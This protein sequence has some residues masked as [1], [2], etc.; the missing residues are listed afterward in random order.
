MYTKTYTLEE[1]RRIIKAEQSM[2]R[3]I[4][5]RKAKR[6]VFGIICLLTVIAEFTMAHFNLIDE[7]GAFAIMLPLGLY[8]LITKEKVIE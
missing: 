7:G 3:E 6:K 8:L 4:L 1:A 2:K 5:L